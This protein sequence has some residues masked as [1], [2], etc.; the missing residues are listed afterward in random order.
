MIEPKFSIG[1][2][3]DARK[4]RMAVFVEEQGYQNEFD[5]DDQTAWHLVL[6][7]DNIP[8][9]TARLLEVDPETYRIG[10]VAVLSQYRHRKVGSYLVKFM[11]TKARTLGARKVILGAQLDKA[12]F[13]QKLGYSPNAE[14]EVY[15]D[16]GHPHIM[17]EKILVKKHGY[18]R[19]A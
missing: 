9:G 12:P 17:M 19:S 10:R 3:P 15:L 8:M 2:T 16:E 1:L 14:G 5:D 4:I 11:E 13:Y 6:Y 18:G 7:S